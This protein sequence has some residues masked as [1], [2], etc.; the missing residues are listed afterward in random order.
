MNEALAAI[1]HRQSVNPARQELRVGVPEGRLSELAVE[2]AGGEVMRCK[3]DAMDARADFLDREAGAF[4]GLD[5][6]GPGGSLIGEVVA[7]FET[8]GSVVLEVGRPDGRSLLLPL[9]P[10]VVEAVD[11]EAGKL[12]IGDIEGFTV[13]DGGPRLV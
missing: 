2:P 7:G 6:Y 8:K 9:V 13:D 3:I 10:E 4:M 5:V 11:W 1:G 12:F